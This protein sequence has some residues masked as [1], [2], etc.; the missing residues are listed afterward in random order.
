MWQGERQS[1]R[2]HRV[3]EERATQRERQTG[4]V[5]TE[6]ARSQ[7]DPEGGA[8]STEE[9]EAESGR[10]AG[11]V[12]AHRHPGLVTDEGERGRRRRAADTEGRGE[13]DG[14]RPPGFVSP[15]AVG[16]ECYRPTPNERV[17]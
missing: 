10:S 3:H 1:Q 9:R 7:R 17:G 2:G 12:G 6:G 13:E 8:A 11:G 14:E 5:G 15:L 4:R 16:A